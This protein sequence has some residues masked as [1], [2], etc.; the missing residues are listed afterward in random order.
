MEKR[1]L[2]I[3]EASEY[4]SLSKSTLYHKVSY[5]EIPVIKVSDKTIKRNGGIVNIGGIRFDIADLNDWIERKK[6]LI[7][8]ADKI[9]NVIDKSVSI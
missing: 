5:G 6:V 2:N 7:C 9:N 8:T 4:L 1:L 3:K